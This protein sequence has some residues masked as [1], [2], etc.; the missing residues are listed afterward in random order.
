M[1]APTLAVPGATS[2]QHIRE[3]ENMYE[4][5]KRTGKKAPD[6]SEEGTKESCMR[7]NMELNQVCDDPHTAWQ[8]S[9][10][11]NVLLNHSDMSLSLHK[12]ADMS[13][14]L[15]AKAMPQQT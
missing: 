5:Q 15:K 3:P 14:L 2:E 6:C 7:A 4:F 9:F 12:N 1:Q 8:Y 11:Q 10:Q 13:P